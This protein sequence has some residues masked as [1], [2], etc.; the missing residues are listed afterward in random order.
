MNFTDQI[1]QL[2]SKENAIWSAQVVYSS[3]S[4]A[5]LSGRFSY[6]CRVIARDRVSIERKQGQARV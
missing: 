6:F 3:T 1:H 4:F 2:Y 5:I